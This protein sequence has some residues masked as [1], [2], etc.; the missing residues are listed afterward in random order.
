M[1]C[2][3]LNDRLIDFI[4]GQLE[5]EEELDVKRH[6]DSCADCLQELESLRSLLEDIG[7]FGKSYNE[8]ENIHWANY[9][10][11]VRERINRKKRRSC[12]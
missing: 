9:L 3:N 11:Q 5:K 7:S 2:N 12:G 6:I 10:P 8:E 1:N 4:E